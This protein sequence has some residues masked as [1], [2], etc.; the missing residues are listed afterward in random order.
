VAEKK[1]ESPSQIVSRTYSILF[2]GRFETVFEPVPGP[3]TMNVPN[4][5]LHDMPCVDK[6]G[7]LPQ[8]EV[9]TL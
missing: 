3:S 6:R 7:P 2:S 4:E 8:M 5:P 1:I 9:D